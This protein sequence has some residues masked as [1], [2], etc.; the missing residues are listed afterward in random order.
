MSGS[1]KNGSKTAY[2]YDAS[3]QLSHLMFSKNSDTIYKA[4]YQTNEKGNPEDI[5]ITS[6]GN[7][8]LHYNYDGLNR[9]TGNSCGPLIAERTYVDGTNGTSNLVE[10]YTNR[11][12]AGV[13]RQYEY[14]Y[15]QNSNITEI[16]EP[17]S[18]ETTTYTYDGLNRLTGESGTN[19]E[20]AY[21][22]D[23]GGNLTTVTN[24]DGS[25]VYRTYTY[26]NTNWKDQLTSINNNAITYDASGN[27]LTYNG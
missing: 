24:G 4:R 12:S 21:N 6:L 17:L 1:Q 2:D 5:I 23:V 3:G 13:F 7:T 16:I 9:L 19:G 11:I 14:V 15:D 10:M 8:L 20:Y 25:V 22:Y 26:G 27:P 18:A